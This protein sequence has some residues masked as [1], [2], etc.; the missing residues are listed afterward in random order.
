MRDWPR[1]SI[2]EE[3]LEGELIVSILCSLRRCRGIRV[4][5]QRY[6]PFARRLGVDPGTMLHPSIGGGNPRYCGTGSPRQSHSEEREAHLFV[7]DL[8]AI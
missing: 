5:T 6:R 8:L 7:N 1:D 2:K 3:K 4:R